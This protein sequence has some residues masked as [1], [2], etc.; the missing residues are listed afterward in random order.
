[1]T[2]AMTAWAIGDLIWFVS[3]NV[4]HIS[5]FPSAADFFYLLFPVL[6]AVALALFS[7]QRHQSPLRIVL[8][9]I[10]VALCLFLLAW[11]FSLHEVYETYRDDRVALALALVYPA[12]DVLAVSV[13][14]SVLVRADVRQRVVLYLLGLA[15]GL[16][17]ISDSAFAYLV[18]EDR[19]VS[20]SYIDLG[21]LAALVLIVAAT[22]RS[23]TARLPTRSIAPSVPSN[24]SLWLP[25]VPLLLAGT[26]GPVM[27]MSGLERIIVPFVVATVC[28]RQSVTAW[29]NRRLLRA[30]A[31]QALTDPLT[32]LANRAL[33]TDR[34]AHAMMLRL[35]ESRSVAVVSLDL[36]DFKLVNDSLGH[37]TADR[38]LVHVGR[39][40]A[41]CV[42]TGDTVA[43][44]GGDEF[45]VLLESDVDDSN[46]VAQRVIEAFNKPFL[47]D[48]QNI[49][50]R[51][52]VGVA[53]AS[54]DEPDLSPDSL[55][56]RADIAMHAAKRSRSPRVHTFTTDMLTTEPDEAEWA[57]TGADQAPGNG[58]AQ[59]RL[60]GELRRAVDTGALNVMYQPKY[61]FRTGVAVGVEA[62][63]RW[64]HPELGVLRPDAFM[65]LVRQHGL[66]R[67]V[68]DL[69]LDKVLDDAAR[70]AARGAYMPVAVNLFAPFLHDTRLPDT[71][72]DA[73][74][75]RGLPAD[76]LTV[77]I[78]EDLVLTE[79]NV[80]TAVLQRLR[81]LGIRVAID[82]FG[83]GYSALSYLR[84]LPIDELKMDR[85][86][87]GSVTCDNRAA[88]VVRAV[89]ELA[90]DLDSTVVAEGIEDAAT[91]AWLRDQG[92]DVGQGYY[93]GKPIDAS[94]VPQLIK[95]AAQPN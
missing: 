18:A 13:A 82:D 32:G 91:A 51:P 92:C 77:E 86:F 46:L 73:L 88:A 85:H 43:R 37:P 49:L 34:L 57:G 67:P 27:V 26:V 2:A 11:I 23:R 21:W 76:L 70:W 66:M 81:H 16:V 56:K 68:T 3:E 36:D 24:S 30:A 90:H 62:L 38:L 50:M 44:V 14:I 47:V 87:I 6:A 71:L 72:C 74:Q 95:V 1:M 64:P 79:L 84:E 63:L 10:T 17:L 54:P 69:V 93:F 5:P 48:G 53:V 19:Y 8:D 83:S 9:G 29:E 75:R 28:V 20:G 12:A 89:I 58:A 4:L 55:T 33:F 40:I 41:E 39:R 35:R 42:R 80:V 25:Y 31:E 15:F 7:V 61:D 45:S 78:T 65:S 94:G 59:V 22:V 52:S 60:L